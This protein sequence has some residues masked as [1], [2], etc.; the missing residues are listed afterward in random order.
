M[1]HGAAEQMSRV[2]GIRAELDFIMCLPGPRFADLYVPANQDQA[3][4]LLGRGQS[5]KRSQNSVE[6]QCGLYHVYAILLNLTGEVRQHD[7]EAGCHI[8]RGSCP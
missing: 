2:L 1:D 7:T 6:K 8:P 5:C 3:I 4:G